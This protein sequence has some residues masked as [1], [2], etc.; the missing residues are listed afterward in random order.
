MIEGFSIIAIFGVAQWAEARALYLTIPN[1]L[2]ARNGFASLINTRARDS[3]KDFPIAAHC[4]MHIEK[5]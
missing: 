5:N 3:Q 2:S 1:T 4:I